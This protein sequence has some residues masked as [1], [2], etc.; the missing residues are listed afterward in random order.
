[1]NM[2][3]QVTTFIYSPNYIHHSKTQFR[4]LTNVYIFYILFMGDAFIK[5][6]HGK[7]KT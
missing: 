6:A 1:M 3:V 7:P 4:T 2:D 5:F